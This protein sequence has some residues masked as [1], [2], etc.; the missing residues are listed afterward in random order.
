MF[1]S[2]KLETLAADNGGELPEYTWPGV[3]ALVYVDQ[4]NETLCQSCASKADES[5]CDA[6]VT[7]YFSS[8]SLENDTPVYCAECQVVIVEALD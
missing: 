5:N 8:E 2:K 1:W 6:K 4:Y 3:Y 7:D